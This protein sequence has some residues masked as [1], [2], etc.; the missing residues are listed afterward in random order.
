M[1]LYLARGFNPGWTERQKVYFATAP[2]RCNPLATSK[3]WNWSHVPESSW[4][5]KK[6]AED[7]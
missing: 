6:P 2:W 7:V 1:N 3:E 5:F 4:W